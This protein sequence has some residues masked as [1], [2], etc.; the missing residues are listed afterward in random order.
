M[1]PWR[2]HDPEVFAATIMTAAE[3]LGV[4]PLV[5]EKDYWVCE[6]LRA[7]VDAYGGE[8][9]FKGGT[10][11]EKLR[12][13]QRFSEDLD[14][15]VIGEY[16][17]IRAPKRTMKAMLETAEQVV[18]GQ[19]TGEESGGKRGAR[20]QKAYLELPLVHGDSIGVLADPK[21]ILLELGQ[22]GGPRP[23]HVTSVE[24]LLYRQLSSTTLAGK[25]DDLRP[26]DV[27][28]LHPGRTLIEKLLR[29]NNF[30]G[31]SDPAHGS[32]RASPDWASVLR[33]LGVARR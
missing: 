32:T 6:V 10:S 19:C 16:T 15:L 3:Q 1:A 29:V 24:S 13:I 18:G 14:L 17:S 27:N 11:L 33:H 20:W 21:A 7:L 5:V 22:T 8:I 30:V 25:W 12:L 9:V 31:R 4:Q 23:S 26:F 2:K 28:I